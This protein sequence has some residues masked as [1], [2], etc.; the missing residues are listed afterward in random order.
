[1]RIGFIGAG[2]IGSTLAQ[3]AVDHGHDVVLS[4]SRGPETLRDLVSQLGEHASAS[5]PEDAEQEG[6]VVVVTIPL[7]AQGDV[8]TGHTFGKVVID[9]ENYYPQR[10]GHFAELDEGRTTSSEMLARHLPGAKVVKAF[11][12]IRFD[13][14]AKDGKPA[15]S[16]DRRALPIAGDDPDAKQVVG[17]L[18]NEFGFDV[19]D[20]GPLSEGR[21]FEPG[22]PSYTARLTA[23][24]LRRE[25]ARV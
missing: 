24:E 15:G 20:A 21:R 19:V 6:D 11:N 18:I 17:R 1:M 10:D 12:S 7:K 16:P 3:L 2:K 13:D 23:D 8:P 25:L 22:T 5:T 14:L 9:T 4:N